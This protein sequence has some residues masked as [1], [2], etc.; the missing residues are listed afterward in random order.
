MPGLSETSKTS[1]QSEC[2]SSVSERDDDQ[3]EV[4]SVS[5]SNVAPVPARVL[6]RARKAYLLLMMCVRGSA[7]LLA[8]LRDVPSGDAN[9]VWRRLERRFEQPTRVGKQQLL[10]AFWQIKQS[11]NEGADQ[12]GA[13]VKNAARALEAA[14][15]KISADSKLITFLDGLLPVF[16]HVQAALLIQDEVTFEQACDAVCNYESRVTQEREKRFGGEEQAYRAF[17][18][19]R[20]GGSGE[21]FGCGEKGHMKNECEVIKS[22]VRCSFCNKRGHTERVCFDKQDAEKRGEKKKTAISMHKIVEKVPPKSGSVDL[23]RYAWMDED[24][25]DSVWA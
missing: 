25:D 12:Y 18:E 2:A 24:S 17:A 10:R 20:G 8:Y 7:D 23:S 22:G 16:R 21:C 5:G 4:E 1:V 13:R 6:Q 14:G 11:H 9:G 15:E 19:R 3:D